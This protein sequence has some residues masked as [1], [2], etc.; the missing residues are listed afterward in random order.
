MYPVFRKRGAFQGNFEGRKEF[1]ALV[2]YC[3][4]QAVE[5]FPGEHWDK[6]DIDQIPIVYVAAGETAGMCRTK[7]VGYGNFKRYQFNLEFN[8][9]HIKHE[10]KDMAY[11]TIPHE[12]AHLVDTLI[13][14]KS[15]HD[16]H[17]QRIARTL[18]CSGSRTHNYKSTKRARKTTQHKY[19]AECGTEI[20]VSTQMHNKLQNGSRRRVT[21]TGGA[22]RKEH[23]AR[24]TRVKS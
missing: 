13:R 14:G 11:D 23:Y 3:L 4:E 1:T 7:I 18:G 5:A 16:S 22:L 21:A 17:W 9:Q 12:V 24:Q 6:T 15:N 10:W 20:W 19:I 2:R 8:V